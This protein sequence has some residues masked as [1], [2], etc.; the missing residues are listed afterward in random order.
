[1]RLARRK[2]D[3]WSVSCGVLESVVDVELACICAL[4]ILR[5]VLYGMVS[6]TA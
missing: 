1:M 3:G 4:A 6:Q 5:T 2:S